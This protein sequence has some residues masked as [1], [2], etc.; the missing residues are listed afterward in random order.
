MLTIGTE[1][2][3]GDSINT[4]AASLGKLLVN[5]GL[6]L[7]QELCVRDS[8]EDIESGLNFLIKYNSS[9]IISGGLGPTEDDITKNSL[10]LIT[11]IPLIEDTVHIENMKKL[12]TKRGYEMSVKQ[13]IDN[14]EQYVN[15]LEDQLSHAL[16]ELEGVYSLVEKYPNNMELGKKIRE[17]YYN[18]KEATPD[19]IEE[20]AK[21]IREDEY[22]YNTEFGF[23]DDRTDEEMEAIDRKNQME[24][25]DED[26][27]E[28]PNQLELP[29]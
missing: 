27:K 12:W 22:P 4:N 28:N 9:I 15:N 3:I 2:L 23:E 20:A 21:T 10:S 1:L 26:S 6:E 19:P 13:S 5:K 29:F 14:I 7:N 17:L 18:R 8:K 24:L 16:Q 11:G 25:F